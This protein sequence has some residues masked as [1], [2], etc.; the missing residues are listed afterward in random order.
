MKIQREG[1]DVF[2]TS[3]GNERFYSKTGLRQRE[4]LSYTW[5]S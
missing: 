1:F 3:D 5:F 2:E 4:T